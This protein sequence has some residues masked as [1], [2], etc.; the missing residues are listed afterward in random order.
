MFFAVVGL[1]SDPFLRPFCCLGVLKD[2]CSL[3]SFEEKRPSSWDLH[4]CCSQEEWGTLMFFMTKPGAGT[5]P[6]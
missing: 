1:V 3:V 4:R 5:V 2:D 6:R